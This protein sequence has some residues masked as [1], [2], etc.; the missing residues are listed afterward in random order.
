MTTEPITSAAE[1]PHLTNIPFATKWRSFGTGVGIEVTPESLFATITVVRPSGIKV[2]DSLEIPRYR[3][4]PAAEWGADYLAFLKKHKLQQ[5]SAAVVLPAA[6]CISRSIPMPGVSAQELSAAIQYQL[7][8]LH[9]FSEDEATHSFSRLAGSRS[10]SVAIAIAKREVIEDYATLFDEAGIDLY[11]F[12]SP[13]AAIYS[14]LRILQ[15]P[16]ASQFLA[17]HEDAAGLLLYGES[18]T[19]PIY[20]VRFPAS[21]DRALSSSAAQLRLPED[22]PQARLAS[23]LPAAEKFDVAGPLSFAA[24]LASAV[25]SLSLPVNL[26]PMARRRLKS[27]WRWVPTLI[28][29]ALLMVLGIGFATYQE[30]ENKRILNRLDAEIAKLQ[31][32]LANVRNLDSEIEVASKKLKYF[33]GMAT[34]PQQDLES[35]RE[36]TRI[37]P[38]S[39]FVSRLDMTRDEVLVAGETDQSLEMLK[40]L[41]SSPYFKDSEFTSS[42]NR[43]PN[44]KDVF[45]MRSKRELPSA[46]PPAAAAPNVPPNAQPAPN[47]TPLPPRIAPPPPL[48]LQGYRP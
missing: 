3:E 23:L 41:D 1:I 31:P 7:E 8:G 47:S 36:L 19:H 14:A 11:S 45:Q 9:P 38:M 40:T 17:I 20:C 15:L 25:P 10:A 43:L 13:A 6:D 12:L 35:L 28:L 29:V 2:L 34:Q 42:P 32:R 21:S 37:I 26:L 48:P 39:A 5:L 46:A 22:A 44:G 18:D 27:P 24:S 33:S 4:R 16:P 30:Y